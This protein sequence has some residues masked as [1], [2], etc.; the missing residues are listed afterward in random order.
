MRRLIAIC[1]SGVTV[2]IATVVVAVGLAMG[3]GETVIDLGFFIFLFAGL[4]LYW[5]LGALIV[6]RARGHIVG[7]LLAVA[8]AMMA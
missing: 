7:W 2:L 6:M 8:A 3:A 4:W 1:G 5:G